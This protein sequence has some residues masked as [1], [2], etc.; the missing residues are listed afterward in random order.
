[1]QIS[2]RVLQSQLPQ[3]PDPALIAPQ[4]AAEWSADQT[5]SS[6]DPQ[7]VT[8]LL[9]SMA[10]QP[11]PR[12]QE[13]GYDIGRLVR[14]FSEMDPMHWGGALQMISSDLGMDVARQVQA[15]LFE[16]QA[17][18][19]QRS[20]YAKGQRSASMDYGTPF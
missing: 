17:Y 8:D 5:L 6:I 3:Q 2:N 13:S 1:M 15:Q 9:G 20:P 19:G 12:P 10:P 16:A 18:L 11:T 7:A 14:S 4:A